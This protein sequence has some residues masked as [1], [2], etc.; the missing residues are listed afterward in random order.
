MPTYVVTSCFWQ[1]VDH[2]QTLI[3]GGAALLAAGITTIVLICQIRETAHHADD[4]RQRRARA[5]LAVLPLALSELQQYAGS[6]IRGLYELRPYFQNHGSLDRAQADKCLSAWPSPRLPE[7][8]L[9]VLKECIEFSDQAPA[10]AASTLIRRLQ[11][12]Q[13]RLTEYASRLRL[14]NHA[15]PLSTIDLAI[16]DTAEV[17]ARVGRLFLF[18]RDCPVQAFDVGRDDVYGAL[19]D[20]GCFDNDQVIIGEL[21]DTWKRE[22]LA[23]EEFGKKRLASRPRPPSSLFNRSRKQRQ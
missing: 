3:A 10:E 6:C 21:A 1:I 12:Q 17:F 22:C 18:S 11:V 5:A 23:R 20:A 19:S 4:Q 7:D 15:L 16:G 9:S 2:W 13:S 14:L 8:V